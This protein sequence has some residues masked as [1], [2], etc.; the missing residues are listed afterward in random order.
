MCVDN[1]NVTDDSSIYVQVELAKDFLKESEIKPDE[2][3]DE[4][5]GIF[6]I[7]FREIWDTGERDLLRIKEKLYH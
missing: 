4:W 1:N 5:V 2:I 7:R 3:I 6:A